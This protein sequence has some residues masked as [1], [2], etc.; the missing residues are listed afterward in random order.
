LFDGKHGVSEELGDFISCHEKESSSAMSTK[1]H[2]ITNNKTVIT[3]YNAL[4][5][6]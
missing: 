1:Q 4:T 6:V 5:F 3:N 2:G